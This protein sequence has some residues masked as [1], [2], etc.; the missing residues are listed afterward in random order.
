M[1]RPL[2]VTIIAFLALIGGLFGLC[3]PTLGM[4]GSTLLGP[5]A[6]VGVVASLFF[7]VGPVLQ[8]IFAAGAFG[9]R[10]WAWYLGLAGAGITVVGVIVNILQ[11]ASF[12]SAVWGGIIPIVIFIY[13]LTPDVRKA[14]GQGPQYTAGS[15]RT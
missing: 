12:G 4:L 10:P 9:L 5:L 8:L 11:G 14:F 15:G 7:I 2:G 6:V 3:L 13:L 1:K